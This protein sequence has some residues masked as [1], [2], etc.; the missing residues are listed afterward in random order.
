[1]PGR[2]ARG[3]SRRQPARCGW[4]RD[5]S[6]MG[7]PQTQ[8]LT[9]QQ[10]CA[11][12]ELL[13]VDVDGVLTDGRIVYGTGELEVKAF[14]VR[15]GSGRN[16]WHRAGKRSAII[17]GRTSPTVTV[18]AAELGV[19][20]VVQRADDK[21]RALRQVLAE[22]GVGEGAVCYVG[23]DLPDL[24]PMSCCVLAVAVG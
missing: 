14:H 22:A 20:A 21:L 15:D 1:S 5:R 9:L 18:R 3:R 2:K 7:D 12:V 17:T 13:V 4:G 8:P 23:D 11:R 19:H 16:L 24:A 6:D 10:R